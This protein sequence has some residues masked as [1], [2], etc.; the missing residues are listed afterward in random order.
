VRHLHALIEMSMPLAAPVF[1]GR[2]AR[3]IRAPLR[4]RVP[5]H[6]AALALRQLIDR[7]NGRRKPRVLQDTYRCGP[8]WIRAAR[9]LNCVARNSRIAASKTRRPLS[10]REQRSRLLLAREINRSG[11]TRRIGA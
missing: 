7:S 8:V 2:A 11:R 4:G 1:K 9:T 6:E 10:P 3:R 5:S